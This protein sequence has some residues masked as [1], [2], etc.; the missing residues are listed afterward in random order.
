MNSITN[1]TQGIYKDCKKNN[2][3]L[4]LATK[5]QNDNE[6]LQSAI[7]NDEIIIGENR[8]QEA[9][10]KQEIFQRFSNKKHFI[11]T[12]QKNKVRKAVTFFDC[13]ETIDSLPLLQRINKIAKEENKN[14]EVFININIS[15]DEKKSG[16][17]K[18]EVLN[19]F[20][21]KEVDKYQNIKITGLFTI[22]KFGLSDDEK[23]KYYKEMKCFFYDI[24]NICNAKHFTQLSM[25]MSA[26]YK[27][28][29]E[30]GATIV[31]I[32]SAIFGKRNKL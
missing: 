27:I 22:L 14:I 11:G 13:I 25:G 17:S 9:E 19:F 3:Q 10:K 29:I 21:N 24:K 12:L 23:R 30:E 16:M 2:V 6:V 20:I 28:A 15:N 7:I 5:N 26:D 1:N 18:K 32:G 8:V 4:L 31:R